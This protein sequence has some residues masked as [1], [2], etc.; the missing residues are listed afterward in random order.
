MPK[1]LVVFVHGWGAGEV[2]WWGTTKTSFPSH[3]KAAD[4]HFHFHH[5]QT[6]KAPQL[7]LW[8]SLRNLLRGSEATERIGELGQT[9]WTTLAFEVERSGAKEIVLF[10][11]SFGGIVLADTIR[12]A[13]KRESM[14]EGDR[15]LLSR[16]RH[17]ALCASPMSGASLA[18]TYLKLVSPLGATNDHVVNLLRN[19]RD[20]ED[21]VNV[22]VNF[23]KRPDAPLLTLFYAAGDAVVQRPEAFEPFDRALVS[24]H[25]AA[26]EG[27]HSDCIQNVGPTSGRHKNYERVA[28]WLFRLP[29]AT[30]APTPPTRAEAIRLRQ[31]FDNLFSSLE[32]TLNEDPFRSWEELRGNSTVKGSYLLRVFL[33]QLIFVASRMNSHALGSANLWVAHPAGDALHLRSDEREGYFATTQ[34]ITISAERVDF[35]PNRVIEKAQ[36]FERNS[37]GARAHLRDEPTL[38]AVDKSAF[39]SAQDELIG[40]THILGVPLFRK[41]DLDNEQPDRRKGMPL[42]ITV[43]FSYDEEPSAMECEEL[44]SAGKRLSSLFRRFLDQ[45]PRDEDRRLS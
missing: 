5:F 16:I 37:A 28:A 34:L 12:H 2:D 9:L 7:K 38:V 31:S 26:L 39:P 25:E 35:R 27:G 44:V 17:I 21:A 4:F 15:Q 45:W 11:H 32:K 29:V 18:E 8:A 6:S 19:N 40:V 42:V 22:F 3:P 30:T 13:V 41:E 20:R 43:D 23:L 1:Q 33:Q 14:H 24:Y 36:D 10:G